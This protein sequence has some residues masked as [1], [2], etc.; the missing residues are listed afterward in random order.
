MAAAQGVIGRGPRPARPPSPLLFGPALCLKR[1]DRRLRRGPDRGVAQLVEYRSPKPVV[2]GSSPAAPASYQAVRPNRQRSAV[3]LH[4]VRIERHNCARRLRG[5]FQAS[6][7]FGG[8]ALFLHAQAQAHIDR[9][10]ERAAARAQFDCAD[11]GAA[12]DA[13]ERGGDE[14]AA[15]EKA[16]N[17]GGSHPGRASRDLAA[18]FVAQTAA[19]AKKLGSST[20]GVDRRR[21]GCVAFSLPQRSPRTAS[22]HRAVAFR[23]FNVRRVS[24]DRNDGDALV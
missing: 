19:G 24:F 21:A 10:N 8:N 20:V 9:P 7:E 23:C 11:P 12:G 4:I 18:R 13:G 6:N 16:G 17:P 2:A 22:V 1:R 14:N 3:S 5:A 15:Q